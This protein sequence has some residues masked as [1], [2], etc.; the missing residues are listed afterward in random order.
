[1]SMNFSGIYAN[2][3]KKRGRK[4]NMLEIPLDICYNKS[5]NFTKFGARRTS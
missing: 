4:K 3:S 2:F 5:V 1:M